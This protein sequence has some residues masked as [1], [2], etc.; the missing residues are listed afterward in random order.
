MNLIT[1]NFFSQKS[2]LPKTGNH[3][4]A[5]YDDE[6][7]VVYQAYNVDIGLFA[8]ENKYFERGFSFTRMSW[9]KTSFLWMMYRSGWAWKEGQEII[10]AVRIK[11]DAFDEILSL[12]VHSSFNENVYNTRENWKD[13]LSKSNVRLQWDPDRHPSGAPLERRAI[14]LGIRGD[15]LRRYSK[16]WILDIENIT[17]F[18]KA[19]YEFL[20]NKEYDKLSV[21]VENSYPVQNKNI[22]DKLKLDE[23]TL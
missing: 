6:S 1:E 21:P 19:Q 16:E 11:R 5:L 22:A 15:T 12:A 10:L 9:I 4:L 13:A 14:Q 3:I 17:D 7:I 23:H 2:E 8:S 18:V 20:K